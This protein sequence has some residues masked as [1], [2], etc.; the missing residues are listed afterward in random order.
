M[1]GVNSNNNSNTEIVQYIF[2]DAYSI[3]ISLYPN[4]DDQAEEVL[5]FCCCL[6]LLLRRDDHLLRPYTYIYIYG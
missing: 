4:N 6:L 5:L 1:G 3:I 2:T